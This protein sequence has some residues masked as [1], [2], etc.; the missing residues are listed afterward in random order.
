MRALL[1]PPQAESD[2][3]MDLTGQELQVLSELDSKHFGLIV[4]KPWRHD[5]AG[6]VIVSS[7]RVMISPAGVSVYKHSIDRLWS[8]W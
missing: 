6:D 3:K 7:D 4:S 8:T 2:L 1:T 5:L